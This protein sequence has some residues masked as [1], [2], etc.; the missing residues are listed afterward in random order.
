MLE[1]GLPYISRR[2]SP[3]GITLYG[4]APLEIFHQYEAQGIT[5]IRIPSECE[6][7]H[8]RKENR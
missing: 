8:Q 4:K 2:L 1:E 3:T 6:Q 7:A 5:L